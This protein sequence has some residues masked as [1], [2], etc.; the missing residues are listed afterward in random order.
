[1]K[2]GWLDDLTSWLWSVVKL[3][4]DAFYDFMSDLFLRTLEQV[5]ALIL[6][7]LSLLP[8]PEFMSK[9]SIGEML[10]NG[11]SSVLW[12]ADVFQIGPSIVMIGVAMVFYLLRR[13]LTVGIW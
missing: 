11:G 2:A 4:W 6:L 9:T 5:F 1:M 7:V 12:F 13:V 10:A 8:L 3:L